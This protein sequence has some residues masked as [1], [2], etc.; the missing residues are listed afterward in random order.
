MAIELG[1]TTPVTRPS[2]P[3]LRLGGLG[4]FARPSPAR[5]RMLFTERLALLLETDNPLHTSLVILGRESGGSAFEPI[6]RKIHEDIGSGLPF[7]QAL[8]RHPDVFSSTY[9][10]LVAAGEQGGFLPA[11][12]S[13]LVSMEDKA[14]QL[15][16]TIASSFAYPAFLVVFSIGV[17]LFVLTV[18]FPKFR[19]LFQAIADQLPVTTLVLMTLSD[20]LR[21][22]WAAI[23]GGL[24][25]TV[26]VLVFWL[27]QRVGVEAL[28]RLKL[29]TPFIRNIFIELYLTQSMRVIGLSLGHGVSVPDT[30]RACREVVRNHLFTQFMDRV[31]TEVNEGHGL[32]AGFS[33]SD[34]VPPLARQMLVA[35]EESGKLPLVTT[36]L[37]DF[38]ERELTKRLTVFSKMIE[39]LMLLVMG[40]VVGLIVASL[41]L[42]IF[43]LSRAVH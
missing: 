40:A 22:H 18:V 32:A 29:A 41:I 7:S 37:A 25:A 24:G 28:D 43:K 9:V 38:Y 27:R 20:V 10:N 42:P 34:L 6:V 1:H 30:L 23:L 12:L 36:R 8:A 35:G 39:P 15:R 31:A 5:E 26:G 4:R 14:A 17:V 33:A 11:V 2:A 19:D 13:E 21:Q 3:A 16:A